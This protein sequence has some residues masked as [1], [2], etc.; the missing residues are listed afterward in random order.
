MKKLLIVPVSL[1]TLLV[2]FSFMVSLPNHSAFAI[3]RSPKDSTAKG[4]P[5]EL[6]KIEKS[7]VKEG[8]AKAADRI[9]KWWKS[10]DKQ[11]SK[12]KYDYFIDKNNNGI[13]DRLEKKSKE[14]ASSPAVRPAPKQKESIKP[15]TPTKETVKKKTKEAPKQQEVKEAK[16]MEG[17]KRR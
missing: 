6:K 14:P 10:T 3:D 17:K 7:E 9:S 4:K 11:K 1:I 13:D 8:N 16:K 5:A 15:A 2:F 12:E